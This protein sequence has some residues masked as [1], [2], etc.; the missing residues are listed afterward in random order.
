MQELTSFQY[1]INDKLQSLLFRFLIFFIKNLYF[2][3]SRST[4]NVY[5]GILCGFCRVQV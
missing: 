5:F 1:A 3:S 2:S 4:G